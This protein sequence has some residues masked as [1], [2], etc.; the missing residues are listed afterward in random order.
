VRA[1]FLIVGWLA[2]AN[3]CSAADFAVLN[4][5]F[6]IRHEHRQ[7]I[8]AVTRLYLSNTDT[9]GYVDVPTREIVNF[10]PDLSVVSSPAAP[11]ANSLPELVNTASAR[12]HLDPDLVNSVIGA[13]SG[14]DSNAVSR[15][16]AQG[17]MQLMPQTASR[18]GVADA[19]DPGANID[20][21]TRYLRALLEHYDFDLIKA[22]AAYNAGPQ[23]V[24]QYHGV[25][26]YSET[27]SYVAKIVRDFNRKKLAEE[28]A[29]SVQHSHPAHT[30]TQTA[31]RRPATLRPVSDT[32]DSR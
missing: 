3:C 27:R 10:E 30:T 19:F 23:R 4:N 2:A 20:G 1:C 11:S 7:V 6:S 13:E 22:L 25:P 14:F 9:N 16:G 8:G 28:K 12:Y 17:L 24:E 5:G 29:A 26:P 15:K 18:L 32:S 31:A 21:G